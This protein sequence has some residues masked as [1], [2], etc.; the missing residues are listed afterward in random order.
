MST[1]SPTRAD[2]VYVEDS[3]L[4]TSLHIWH[5]NGKCIISSKV[6]GKGKDRD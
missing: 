2:I 6:D 4:W 3:A 5:G 1:D